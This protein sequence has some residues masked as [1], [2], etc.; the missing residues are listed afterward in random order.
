MQRDIVAGAKRAL[1]GAASVVGGGRGAGAGG[2][3]EARV[4]G[5]GCGEMWVV[6]GWCKR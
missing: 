3:A 2:G 4:Y 1:G 5:G 6:V